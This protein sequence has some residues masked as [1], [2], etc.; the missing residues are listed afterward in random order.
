[1]Q[2]PECLVL[3]VHPPEV[4]ACVS[5]DRPLNFPPQ[6]RA[7]RVELDAEDST[8]SRYDSIPQ[9]QVPARRPSAVQWAQSP[10]VPISKPWSSRA[11]SLQAPIETVSEPR[12]HAACIP[13]TGCLDRLLLLLVLGDLADSLPV[14]EGDFVLGCRLGLG[15]LF[16]VSQD[17]PDPLLVPAWGRFVLLHVFPRRPAI[18]RPT[19]RIALCHLCPGR[20]RGTPATCSEVAIL[21]ALVLRS[22]KAFHRKMRR[23]TPEPVTGPA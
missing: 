8:S 20:S 14:L 19:V 2:G 16:I 11:P 10:S 7:R 3:D 9:V 4:V 12:P 22:D 18:W 1:M 23:C 17:P 13:E 5:A 21:P 6:H 15:L